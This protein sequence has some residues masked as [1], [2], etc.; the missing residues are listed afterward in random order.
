MGKAATEMLVLQYARTHGIRAVVPRFFIHVAPRGVEA[1]ALHEF[2]RQIALIERGL[3]DPVIR[4]G[5][6][7]TRRDI[8]NIVDSAPVVVCLAE[9]A[10]SGTAVNVGSNISYT[11][12]DLL[13]KAVEI[14]GTA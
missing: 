1:L 8:T 11:I 5:D 9:V 6:I 2:A 14:G 12:Q 3:Q 7:S 10:P 13:E 4:H